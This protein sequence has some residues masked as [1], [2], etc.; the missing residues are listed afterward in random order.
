[1]TLGD[2]SAV[3][4]VIWPADEIFSA[5]RMSCSGADQDVMTGFPSCG[6]SLWLVRSLNN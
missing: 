5:R 4:I 2:C 3:V 6:L 1:M